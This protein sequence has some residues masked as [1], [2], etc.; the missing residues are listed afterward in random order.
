MR[1]IVRPLPAQSRCADAIASSED[2]HNVVV[3]LFDKSESTSR[4]EIHL[5]GHALKSLLEIMRAAVEFLSNG[6]K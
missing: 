2:L 6:S 3:P 4:N 1:G 5:Q